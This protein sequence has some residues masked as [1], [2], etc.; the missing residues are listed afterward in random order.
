[1]GWEAPAW[2]PRRAGTQPHVPSPQER[3]TLG[4]YP[5]R[6]PKSRVPGATAQLLASLPPCCV[7]KRPRAPRGAGR[8]ENGRPRKLRP[9][10]PGACLAFR[11]PSAPPARPLVVTKAPN[12]TSVPCQAL[13][14]AALHPVSPQVFL[15][16]KAWDS[17]SKGPAGLAA[18]PLSG[19]HQARVSRAPVGGV[20]PKGPCAPGLPA[21]ELSGPGDRFLINAGPAHRP[22][23]GQAASAASGVATSG[24]R[25]PDTHPGAGD[26]Q[27]LPLPVPTLTALTKLPWARAAPPR[28]PAPHSVT[29]GLGSQRPRPAG[30]RLSR[31]PS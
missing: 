27:S 6:G 12:V 2:L 11:F 29:L 8:W 30:H 5:F 3:I 13:A 14:P 10:R 24:P 22:G 4:F 25:N 17:A 9:P 26:T 1:M 21:M 23:R 15:L 16:P 19:G 31:T 7:N 18:V 20:T 28:V